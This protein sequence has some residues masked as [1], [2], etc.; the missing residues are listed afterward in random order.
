MKNLKSLVLF[1]CLFL[2][3]NISFS[4]T[5]IDKKYSIADLKKDVA[6]L[7]SNL[8]QIHPGLYTYTPKE[9]FDIFFKQKTAYEIA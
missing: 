4:Q 1:F 7:K 2:L 3:G 9:D 5:A 6:I 8:E